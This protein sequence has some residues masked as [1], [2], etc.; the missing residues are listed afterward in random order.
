MR[1]CT[2]GT[3]FWGENITYEEFLEFDKYPYYKRVLH[4]FPFLQKIC[5][6]VRLKKIIKLFPSYRLV[7]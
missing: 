3:L 2:A 5:V 1:A 6:V 7:L 4:I